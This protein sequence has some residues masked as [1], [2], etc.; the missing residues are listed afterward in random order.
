MFESIVNYKSEYIPDRNG[1]KLRFAF[2]AEAGEFRRDDNGELIAD[3]TDGQPF[4][5]WRDHIRKP[6]DIWEELVKA[7]QIPGT[8]SAPRLQP[9][10]A[11]L[12]MLQSGMRAPMGIKVRAPDLVTLET[13]C[14]DF[15]RLLK[16]VPSVQ[17]QAVLADRVVGKPYIELEI[18]RD[19][20]A[21]HGL[22]ITQVQDIIEVAIGGKPLTTSVEGRE[23]YPI[24][25]RYA[26]ELRD[27]VQAIEDIY[28]PTPDGHRIPLA[29]LAEVRYVQGPQ[30]IK[31]EDTFLTGYVLF[32]MKKGK[33]EVAVVEECVAYLQE[34]IDSG[35][36]QI[37]AGVSYKFA[38][39]YENQTRSEE[40]LRLL[41]PLALFVIFIILY[42]QFGRVSTTFLV[43][44]GIL[45]AWAGGFI[46]I[47]LYGQP[48]FLDF[49]LLDTNMRELFGV[50]S[51][52]LSV[53]IWIGFIA[54]FGIASDDG[55]VVATY[56]DQ[57]FAANPTQ[58]VAGVRAATLAAG[59]RRIRPC[60]M[61]TATTI[62]AL[63]PVLTSSGRGADI[64]IP[65]AIPSF[66][67]M[68]VELVTL[69]VVP[70]LYCALA[71]RRLGN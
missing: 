46:M 23:R 54:L 17:A 37:P 48:W 57:A 26:R 40:R 41:L 8:T 15:E 20:I 11:R 18:D 31:S 19:A 34:K 24:R 28:V 29:Q 30:V 33:A 50:H 1:R 71:E 39:S 58:T 6:H 2:D 60:L 32:D 10:A 68:C 7:A 22:M 14:L 45:V 70:T 42:F 47:W 69:F 59:T 65:M 21:R 35:E 25:V 3:A 36:L 61:T 55:V 5:Q 16:D 13:V 9:I 67:G 56:L 44:S 49:S 62:L 4:R 38:G 66:G 51:I 27:S 53:A 52:N 12:V 64:M 63:V 43:F